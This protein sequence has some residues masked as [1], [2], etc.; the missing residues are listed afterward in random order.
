[1]DKIGKEFQLDEYYLELLDEG[2]LGLNAPNALENK[3]RY[4]SQSEIVD[5]PYP[6][7]RPF[8]TTEAPIFFGRDG[9]ADKLVEK[10][11]EYNFLGVIGS[12]GSG[13][14]SLI[15]AGLIPHLFAGF[16]KDGSSNWQVAICRPGDDPIS[17]ISAA[18]AGVQVGSRE[19]DEI[20]DDA[21]RIRNELN[22]NPYGL[23]DIGEEITQGKSRLLIV[24]DQFEELFRFKREVNS[25]DSHHF[26]NLLMNVADEKDCHIY[27]AITMRS[28][29]LGDCVHFNGLTEAINRGQYLVPRLGRKELKA[30]IEGPAQMAGT[31]ID[32]GLLNKLISEIGDNM[33]QLPILQHALMRTYAY[34]KKDENAA[35]IDVEH[36]KMA[37]E[38]KGALAQ[39]ADEII[40]ALTPA[41]RQI[42]KAIFQRIT[43]RSSDDR[44]IRRPSYLLQIHEVC[45][46]LHGKYVLNGELVEKSSKATKI[47]ATPKEVNEVI[48]I[49]RDERNAFLMPPKAVQL[50]NNPVIDISHESIMRNWDTLKGWI[51][52]EVHD[53]SLYKRLDQARRDKLEDDTRGTE[54]PFLS[55]ALLND[56]TEAHDR[57]DKNA[58]WAARYHATKSSS[59]QA[60][61]AKNGEEDF[62]KNRSRQTSYPLE[63]DKVVYQQN[64]DYFLACI[65][66]EEALILADEKRRRKFMIMLTVV[67]GISFIAIVVI[68]LSLYWESGRRADSDRERSKLED[69]KAKLIATQD[70]L[71]EE[72][73]A[74]DSAKSNLEIKV[75][76]I[77]QTTLEAEK[78]KQEG[79]LAQIAG[80]RARQ[81]AESAEQRAITLLQ[82][83][84]AAEEYAHTISYQIDSA[85]SVLAEKKDSLQQL[86]QDYH[87]EVAM[88]KR[89]EATVQQLNY[90][91][92]L[93][94][95][96]SKEWYLALNPNE[97]YLT[98]S[99]LYEYYDL[100]INTPIAAIDS[101]DFEIPEKTMHALQFASDAQLNP[102]NDVM[103]Q[104]ATLQIA[105][106]L[107]KNRVVTTIY[108]SI[109]NEL[110]R[111]YFM[112]GVTPWFGDNPQWSNNTVKL[113]T[114]YQSVATMISQPDT[115]T[116]EYPFSL[117][118]SQH[119]LS[120]DY[121]SGDA[122]IAKKEDEGVDWF[123]ADTL[124]YEIIF[125]DPS[126][127]PKFIARSSGDSYIAS[128]RDLSRNIF[129][130][131]STVIVR[132]EKGKELLRTQFIANGLGTSFSQNGRYFVLYN[133]WHN[134]TSSYCKRID[135]INNTVQDFTIGT[136]ALQVKI[137]NNGNDVY[138]TDELGNGIFKYD[139]TKGISHNILENTPTDPV[140]FF[141]LSKNNEYIGASVVDP[142]SISGTLSS[143]FRYYPY[144][145]S[146]I[147]ILNTSTG[148]LINEINWPGEVMFNFEFSPDGKR[149]FTSGDSESYIFSTENS[150]LD[151]TEAAKL[152]DRDAYSEELISMARYYRNSYA[153]DGSSGIE[154]SS[155]YSDACLDLNLVTP[156][157]YLYLASLAKYD[158][159]VEKMNALV[160]SADQLNTERNLRTL[161]DCYELYQFGQRYD[162]LIRLKKEIDVNTSKR[163][164]NFDVALIYQYK[165]E[166]ASSTQER[167]EA[168][169]KSV[170]LFKSIDSL[171]SRKEWF[172]DRVP[173][174]LA[175]SFILADKRPEAFAIIN[176]T[177]IAISEQNRVRLRV[178]LGLYGGMSGY[179]IYNRDLLSY[180]E[181]FLPGR[182]KV[183]EAMCEMKSGKANY[184]IA[185]AALEQAADR[186][187]REYFWM[188]SRKEFEPLR[189]NNR[190][191]KVRDKVKANYFR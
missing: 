178:M 33:D 160:D 115:I 117:E 134:S 9:Q 53:G 89:L 20:L 181:D 64:V 110:D 48:E 183:L 49:L 50:V 179:I 118:S 105:E 140:A 187:F 40:S 126:K 88:K 170:D 63:T 84:Q 51:A 15:R 11:N 107:D 54:H 137:G 128:T 47:S 113:I 152:F 74:V 44:G 5:H 13:K 77:D 175:Y 52:E 1:M 143:D 146:N 93:K 37:G 22:D 106:L 161:M 158:Y 67:L 29:Y 109:L 188:I 163:A 119:I 168:A 162:D 131:D 36:Y 3:V 18:L 70:R 39:H 82:Q 10:L 125:P 96:K 167:I 150:V 177:S 130:E 114:D 156:N 112:H 139:I 141:D 85:M 65:A 95:V 28:E 153:Y 102:T 155:M 55:G 34:W 165:A 32:K 60:E 149:V 97:Q 151:R 68:G 136:E 73:K 14:S 172:E 72:K 171:P 35:F 99:I 190:F 45:A 91:L 122:L 42:A 176:D 23:I 19:A 108:D 180:S 56:L 94:D 166:R 57:N 26:V 61:L 142:G 121:A 92:Y 12:S 4:I 17:N 30:A 27:I 144:S 76:E 101:N 38:M 191:T 2:N 145:N 71:V 154:I 62:L 133:N 111:V 104:L 66:H 90:Q 58:A 124:T 138:Y 31:Q 116:Y 98:D 75:K 21:R 6:G 173:F 135:L 80:K 81:Y 184:D 159:D 120:M 43:D 132:S 147:V 189:N 78:A 100:D 185:L 7:I 186:G 182:E 103:T 41:Q 83:A 86:E 127:K 123:Y 129:M 87:G 174:N 16:H 69:Q 46:F 164:Y 8:K 24:I 79:L 59:F 169:Q 157:L 148:A 25:M